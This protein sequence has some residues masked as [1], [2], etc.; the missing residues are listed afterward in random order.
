VTEPINRAEAYRGNA[1][2]CERT[3]VLATDESAKRIYT[4]LARQWRQKADLAEA[5]ERRLA[6]KHE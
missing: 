3:A 4:D 2:Q 1:E 6:R 5:L